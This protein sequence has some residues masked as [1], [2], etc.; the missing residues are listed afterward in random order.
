MFFTQAAKSEDSATK[1]GPDGDAL[2]QTVAKGIKFLTDVGP[3]GERRD[4]GKS[5]SANGGIEKG[6]R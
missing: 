2:A 5:V 1:I 6:Q 3:I 4:R